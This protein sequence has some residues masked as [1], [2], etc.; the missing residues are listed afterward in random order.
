MQLNNYN[1]F[2]VERKIS[3]SGVVLDE[4]SRNKLLK[5]F[6]IPEGWDV[7]AH[8]MTIKLGELDDKSLIGKKIR[9]KVTKVGKNDKVMAVMVEPEGIKSINKVPHIT[10]AVNRKAGGK[11]V[12]S[13]KIKKWAGIKNNNLYI[14]GTVEEI[15]FK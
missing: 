10:L 6:N 1:K 5:L 8:H 4:E 11:P 3:Y 15:P 14:T 13:N 12:M 7:I 2:T 9:M